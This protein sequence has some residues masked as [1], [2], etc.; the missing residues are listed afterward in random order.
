VLVGA[1]LCIFGLFLQVVHGFDVDACRLFFDG[2]EVWAA[3]AALRALHSRVILVEPLRQSPSYEY[4]LS[5]A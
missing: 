3:E 4:R 1:T 5:S 2:S